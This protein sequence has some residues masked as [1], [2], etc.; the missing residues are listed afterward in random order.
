[1]VKRHL[2]LLALFNLLICGGI[3]AHHV[4]DALCQVESVGCVSAETTEQ[5]LHNGFTLPTVPTTT[6]AV[7]IIFAA[8]LPYLNTAVYVRPPRLRPPLAA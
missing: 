3:V 1:M 8:L 5:T 6:F 7:T 2:F 4:G